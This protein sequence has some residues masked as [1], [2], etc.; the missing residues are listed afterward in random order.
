M[1]KMANGSPPPFFFL[2]WLIIQILYWA[3][4]YSAI[5]PP[6]PKGTSTMILN[7]I[8]NYIVIKEP[9]NTYVS[10]GEY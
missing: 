6:I 3:F 1:L 8:S 4:S 2:V 9:S 10:E 7:Y 5:S